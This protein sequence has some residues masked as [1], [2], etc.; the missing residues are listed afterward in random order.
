MNKLSPEVQQLRE[1]ILQEMAM[2][3]TT[4]RP[5]EHGPGVKGS[6]SLVEVVVTL[7]RRLDEQEIMIKELLEQVQ[8]L[9]RN[10][11]PDLLDQEFGLR[12]N[13]AVGHSR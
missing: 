11:N 8:V 4:D 12:F 6:P 10:G 1:S 7:S 3:P 2:H 13:Q 9:R 5:Y